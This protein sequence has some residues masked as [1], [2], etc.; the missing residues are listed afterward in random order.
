MKKSKV[1]AIVSNGVEEMELVIFVDMLRR[2]GIEVDIVSIKDKVVKCS[3]GVKLLADKTFDEIT[4][5]EEF[6][7]SYDALYIPGGRDNAQNLKNFNH[8]KDIINYFV[9]RN[10]I[11]SAI[12]AGPTV[13]NHHF[14][15]EN[16]KATC[17]PSL[18]NE[19]PNYI[20][21]KVVI[22]GNIITSQGPATTFHLALTMIEKLTNKEIKEIVSN[23]TLFS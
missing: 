7:N 3:R 8:L 23:A 14:P 15:L 9:S 12:C 22:D 13:I 21:S 18:K 4:V 19:L 5:L 16:Y 2:A 6:L 1:L 10:K 20:D 11:V 17:Y